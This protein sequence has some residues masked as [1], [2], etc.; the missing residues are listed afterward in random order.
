MRCGLSSNFPPSTLLSLLPITP[1]GLPCMAAE[2]TVADALHLVDAPIFVVE[3]H[4]LATMDVAPT[5]TMMLLLLPGLYVNFMVGLATPLLDATKGWTQPTSP[6]HSSNIH[7]PISR[8]PSPTTP[9]LPWHMRKIDTPI[10]GWLTM[11]LVSTNTSTYQPRNIKGK[12][13]FM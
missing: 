9:L 3:A 1:I 11:S 6:N 2:A 8:I 12:I 10:P 13:R 7:R 5:S 4:L